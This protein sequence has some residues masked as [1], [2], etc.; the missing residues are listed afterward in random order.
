[1]M[2]ISTNQL[3]N[4]IPCYLENLFKD[5]TY[6]W[7]VLPYVNEYIMEIY[8]FCLK[9]G[10]SEYEPGILIGKNVKI[11]P[12][13]T[14]IAPAIIGHDCEIRPGAYIRGN[15]ITGTGCVI[16]NS[17]EVKNAVLFDYAQI[18]HFNY[19]GDS[20]IGNYAHM[21]AGAVCSNLKADKSMVVVKSTPPINTGLTKFGAILADNA[22]VGC[23]CV[24]NPGAIVCPNA[25][26][27]PL[28]SVRGVIP[29]NSIMKSAD[30]IV[31]IK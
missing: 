3:F 24:L 27:Y 26:I 8:D 17:S 10:F 14:I 6:P 30:T 13:A 9:N 16:G 18:P 20:V 29:S 1:M 28:T 19:V 25:R 22:E 15:V 31:P 11:S 2:E 4:S 5:K 23:G 21:G 7:E 12:L